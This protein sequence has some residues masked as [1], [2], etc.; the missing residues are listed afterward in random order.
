M[1]PSAAPTTAIV[2]APLDALAIPAALDG[3]DGAN[4]A[5]GREAQIVATHDL[6]ALRAWLARFT[7]TKTTFESYRKEAERLLLRTIVKHPRT[8]G[9]WRPFYGPLSP[10]SQRQ[11]MVILNVMFAW[12]VQ[13]G[14]LAGNPLSLS[15]QRARKAPPRITRYLEPELWQEVKAYIGSMPR[16]TARERFH[17]SRVRWLFT[18]LYLGGSRITEVGA[19]TMGQF[20]SRRDAAGRERRWLEVTGKGDRERLVPATAEMMAEL[21][22]YR[23]AQ[24]LSALP[25]P[26]EDTPLVLPVGEARKPL[27]RAALHRI[28]KEVF[29]GAANSFCVRA[30]IRMKS[31]RTALNR[32]Q[33]TG[34]DIARD[35]TWP[36][37]R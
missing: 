23:R 30:A 4:R 11:A 16:E 25:L 19:N 14:Y 32:R 3:R 5:A 26:S 37:S 34:F 1:P 36:I 27:T 10:A 13:A 2:P 9:P 18:L 22:H 35:P 12:L 6:D 21:T 8:D 31:G 20:F 24:D 29:A 7:D 28:V 17:Y 33:P 15:R